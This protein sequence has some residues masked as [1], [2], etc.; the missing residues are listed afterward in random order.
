MATSN[1]E[2]KVIRLVFAG[3]LTVAVDR[4]VHARLRQALEADGELEIDASGA[5]DMDISFLQMLLAAR[6]SALLRGRSVRLVPPAGGI[7]LDTLR[8]AGL[9]A[10]DPELS[11]SGEGFWR[12]ES[13]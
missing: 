8:R 12:G 6:R 11:Y 3:P 7:L 13:A 1:P 9:V 10:A 4:D 5:T 2:A